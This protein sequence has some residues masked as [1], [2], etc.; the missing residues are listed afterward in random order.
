MGDEVLAG[1]A[2]LAGVGDLGERER[3]LDLLEVG[4][5]ALALDPADEGIEAL[6]GR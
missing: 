5:G 3:P 6:G 4:A 1:D 2:L